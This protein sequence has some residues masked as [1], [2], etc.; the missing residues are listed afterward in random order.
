MRLS[1][2]TEEII[3]KWFGDRNLQFDAEFINKAILYHDLILEWSDKIN[4][5]SRSDLDN[6]LERHI[7][8][9]LTPIKEI[10]QKGYLV[11]IGS[12]AGF[13]A[14]PLA[15]IRPELK[16]VM[17]E[18]RKKKAVFLE[19]VISRL[20]IQK[21]SIWNGRLEEFSPVKL[22]DIA[23]IRAVAIT[24]KIKNHLGK[25]TKKTGKVIYYNKFNE[26]QLI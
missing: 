21:A 15:L 12:G 2:K 9:S 14:I 23:T 16:I 17:I 20:D 11:D 1:D 6:L 3:K 5:V 7:L 4:L 18:S 8:D 25:I 24:E 10:P 13:P 22:F 19:E 26:Y